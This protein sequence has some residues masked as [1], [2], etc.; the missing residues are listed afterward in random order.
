MKSSASP[1]AVSSGFTVTARGRAAHG[2]DYETGIDAIQQMAPILERISQLEREIYPQQQHPLLG[3]PSVHASL[4]R[5]GSGLSTYPDR[6]ELRIEH[7]TI[8]GQD[9]ASILADWEGFLRDTA[10]AQKDDMVEVSLDFERPPLEVD[11]N[12]P[13]V[14]SLA[15]VMTLQ[16]GKKPT[17][18]ASFGW[19]D[20][21]LLVTA[22]IPTVILGPRGAGAHAAEE[23]VELESVYRCAS[24]LAETCAKWCA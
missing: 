12:E 4:I 19:L 24:I 14:K 21:A 5:G 2:S 20:S 7:R 3:R 23:W 17:I 1:I 22:G 6:C 11:P 10:V 13:I 15:N 8:P 16:L 9:G 18:G